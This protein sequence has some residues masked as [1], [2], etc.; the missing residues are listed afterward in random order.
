MFFWQQNGNVKHLAV[1]LFHTC[2]PLFYSAVSTLWDNEASFVA[3]ETK[4]NHEESISELIKIFYTQKYLDNILPPV[5]HHTG[6]Q[7]IYQ[8]FLL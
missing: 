3:L 8:D 5:Q 2:E 6:V 7:F 4:T 1:E